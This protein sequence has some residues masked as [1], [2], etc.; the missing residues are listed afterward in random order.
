MAERPT[1]ELLLRALVARRAAGP[2][3]IFWRWLLVRRRD[4]D[5]RVE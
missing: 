4:E 5:A 3:L 1:R 2:G